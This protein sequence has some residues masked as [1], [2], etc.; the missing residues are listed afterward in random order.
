MSEISS[1]SAVRKRGWTLTPGAFHRFLDWLDEGADSGGQKYLETALA[2]DLAVGS[3]REKLGY[4]DSL[5]EWTDRTI[6]LHVRLAPHDQAAA[7]LATLMLL[8]RKG[9]VLDA[10]SDS[11]VDYSAN[12]NVGDQA[13]AVDRFRDVEMVRIVAKSGATYKVAKLSSPNEGQWYNANSVY[14]YFDNRAFTEIMFDY[15][16]YVTPYLP[17][18]GKKHN[19]DSDKV[20]VEGYNAFEACPIKVGRVRFAASGRTRL[21][22]SLWRNLGT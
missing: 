13:I 4:L 14:P 3:E 5:S 10:M 18:Y 6:S 22:I 16:S 8:Q 1:Q 12:L 21:S 7:A 9:G 15:K 11:L 17:C 19:L 2:L 20:T